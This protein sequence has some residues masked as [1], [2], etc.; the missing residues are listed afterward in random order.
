MDAVTAG[1]FGLI[2]GSF[3]NVVILR[4][5]AKSLGGR[6]ECS[7]CR[8]TLAWYDLVPVLSWIVLRGRCRYC[9]SRISGQY[10]L[11]E[12]V[13]ALLF[14]LVWAAPFPY[15]F[16]YRAVACAIAA[17]LIC[18]VAYDFRH[19]IIPDP[20]VYGFDALALVSALLVLP[21]AAPSWS[22]LIGG[23]LAAAPLFLL[24]AVS[25]GRWMGFGDVKL[26]L[27]IGWLLGPLSG[28]FSVLFAFVLGSVTLVPL[29]WYGRLVTHTGWYLYGMRGLTMKSEVPFGPFLIASTLLVWLSHMYGF[30]IPYALGW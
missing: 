23:F 17:L 9:G 14:F 12:I 19:T 15:S 27:G 18:I 2:V 30:D 5:G 4:W 6:S 1:L 29:L 28:L 20:W 26:A 13:T 8:H 3:L 22:L 10:A 7:S 25:G 21:T 24:W 16:L 11:V